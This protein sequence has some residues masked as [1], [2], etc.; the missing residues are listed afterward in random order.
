MIE[1]KGYTGIFEYDDSIDA[2]AGHVVD[3]AGEIYFEGGSIEEVK[4]SMR[5]AV[6]HYLSACEAQGVPPDRPFS[7]RLMIRTRPE[8]HRAVA[9]AA[10]RERRSMNEWIERRLTEATGLKE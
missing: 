7:G 1:Y 10:A 9:L 6:D 8:L 5:R 3:I 2:L 4:E